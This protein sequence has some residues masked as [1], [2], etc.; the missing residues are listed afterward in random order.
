M[1]K[2]YTPEVKARAV[3]YALERLDRYKS[4]YAACADMA[5]KLNV[6]KES[7]RRWILQAQID[8]GERSGPTIEDP[9]FAS[10]H[11]LVST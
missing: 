3:D 2:Q 4:V 9:L 1:P 10:K 7:L 11:L 6:G 5:P 8:A